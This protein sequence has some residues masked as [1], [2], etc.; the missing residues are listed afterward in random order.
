MSIDLEVWS[1]NPLSPVDA[2]SNSSLHRTNSGW[3]S[4][5]PKW[6]IVV[7]DSIEVDAEDVPS[8]IPSRQVGLRFLTRLA[9]EPISAPRS[10]SALLR[11]V[12]R[13]I[14]SRTAGIVYDPQ[15]NCILSPRRSIPVGTEVGES[16]DLIVLSW[17]FLGGPLVTP[18]GTKELL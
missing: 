17:W 18:Q 8:C 6:Q 7:E 9:L 12:A 5:E 13:D 1:A 15:T 16:V 3:V 10:A 14:S 2:H 11:R 4:H